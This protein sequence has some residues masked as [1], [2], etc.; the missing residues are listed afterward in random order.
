[1][2]AALWCAIV[3]LALGTVYCF[4]RFDR[5]TVK[6]EECSDGGCHIWVPGS[7]FSVPFSDT[8]KLL[9][10]MHML[11]SLS[12]R[13]EHVDFGPLLGE[14]NSL[15]G[16][17]EVSNSGKETPVSYLLGELARLEH[18]IRRAHEAKTEKD[19]KNLINEI[20]KYTGKKEES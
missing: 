16:K 4:H 20:K 12:D 1:M 6:F 2:I 3:L 13:V 5:E 9:L 15:K 17:Y 14:G 18:V 7:G 10:L 19:L 11:S 8:K